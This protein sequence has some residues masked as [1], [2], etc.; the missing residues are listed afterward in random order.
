MKTYK[1]MLSYF[2]DADAEY[3]EIRLWEPVGYIEADSE[4][5]AKNKASRKWSVSPEDVQVLDDCPMK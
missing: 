5:S 1:I 4:Q 2:V 3:N